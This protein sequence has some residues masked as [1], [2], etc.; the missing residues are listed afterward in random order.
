M[1]LDQFPA[2]KGLRDDLNGLHLERTVRRD[3]EKRRGIRHVDGRDLHR[4]AIDWVAGEFL[5]TPE[6][7][8]VIELLY[9]ALGSASP[10]VPQSA[11]LRA[12]GS[13][14]RRLEEVFRG[15]PA[16]GRLVVP[17]SRTAHF[18]LPPRPDESGPE[19]RVVRDDD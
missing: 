5:V 17:G 11:L 16:W 13:K 18:C 8:R 4:V 14:A 19:V 1:S 3:G 9:D 7:W 6:Q 10:E 2:L 15:S 12:S